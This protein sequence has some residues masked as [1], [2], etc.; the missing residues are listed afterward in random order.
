[1][2]CTF[3]YLFVGYLTNLIPLIEYAQIKENQVISNGYII[4]KPYIIIFFIYIIIN[5][6]IQNLGFT[7][8]TPLN[9]N[10]V[11]AIC[12]ERV[13]T[14]IVSTHVHKQKSQHDA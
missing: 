11:L 8:P 14:H 4:L 13:Y 5:F 3:L 2:R 7:N 10:L 12:N 9:R 1:M 6:F